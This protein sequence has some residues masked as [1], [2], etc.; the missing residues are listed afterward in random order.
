V[1]VRLAPTQVLSLP[2]S[3]QLEQVAEPLPLPPAQQS[4][5]SAASVPTRRDRQALQ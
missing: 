5:E 4:Q 1:D 2:V 3:A